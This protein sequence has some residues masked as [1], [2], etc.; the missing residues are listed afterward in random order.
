MRSIISQAALQPFNH[1]TLSVSSVVGE[2]LVDGDL[3]VLNLGCQFDDGI[4][5]AVGGRFTV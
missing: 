4:S 3:A 5:T 1:R 2:G